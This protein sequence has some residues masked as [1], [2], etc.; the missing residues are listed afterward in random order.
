MLR[1]GWSLPTRARSGRLPDWFLDEPEVTRSEDAV[2]DAF[3]D[4]STCR[5]VGM[6]IGPIPWDSIA[7][8]ADRSGFGTPAVFSGFVMAIRI[9]DEAYVS[10]RASQRGDP[11]GTES[12]K[13]QGRG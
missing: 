5:D 7:A 1:D 8:Y 3:F 13:E 11:R 9:L 2:I 12:S 4:L 6:G 10:W